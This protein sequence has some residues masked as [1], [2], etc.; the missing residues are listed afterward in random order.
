MQVCKYP[1]MRSALSIC[2]SVEVCKYASIQ[3]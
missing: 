3:V 1:S 2:W